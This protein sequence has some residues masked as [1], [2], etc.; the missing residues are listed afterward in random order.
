MRILILI[1]LPVAALGGTSH[2]TSDTEFSKDV[3][4]GDSS[5]D[6][7]I[8]NATTV[9]AA[10]VTFNGDVTFNEDVE[11][12]VAAD[13]KTTFTL[14]YFTQ[15]R[16]GTGGTPGIALGPD[17]VYV[18]GT[19]EVDGELQADGIFDA[20]STSDFADT[21]T[22]SKGS[23]DAVDISAGGSL[24]TDGPIDANSTS[25][26]A[27]TATFSKGS[28]D[29]ID[30]ASGGA[31]NIDGTVDCNG[32]AAFAEDVTIE[33]GAEV[34]FGT[35]GTHYEMTTGENPLEMHVNNSTNTGNWDEAANIFIYGDGGD[36]TGA[37]RALNARGYARS[38]S[39]YSEI[40]GADL[41]AIQLDGAYAARPLNL[42][43][44][45]FVDVEETEAADCPAEMVTPVFGIVANTGGATYAVNQAKAGI[46]GCVWDN[47]GNDADG[48][49]SMMNGDTGAAP[50]N[51]DTAYYA[52][53]NRRST[54][55]DVH[56]YGIDFYD[57]ATLVPAVRV[58]DIRL[59]NEEY[60]QNNVDGTLAMGVGGATVAY[61]DGTGCIADG[62]N[63]PIGTTTPAEGT[64][65]DV[66]G[67][68]DFSYGGDPGD[69]HLYTRRTQTIK[70]IDGFDM[71]VD[72][73]FA[74]IYDLTNVVG[75]GTNEVTSVDGWNTLTTA[76][77]GGPDSEETTFFGLNHYRVYEP[78]VETV[79]DFTATGGTFFAFG[80]YAA[81][82]E[83]CEI[84]YDTAV[85]AN[86]L[87][88]VDDTGGATT[89]DSGVAVTA[90]P[91]KLELW[92]DATGTPG[93][94]IDDVNIDPGA[95]DDMTASAH[96][97]R[98]N[99]TDIAGVVH[100]VSVDYIE[101]EQ[102]KMQ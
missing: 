29:A 45:M 100:T 88:V 23:G 64:F 57:A 83:L 74:L 99:I 92:V 90:D 13:D 20:N 37:I 54:S 93:W 28:G 52:I 33:D 25:D 9:Q 17:D 60:I 3:T 15:F 66:A 72:V 30:V 87:L 53:R 63:G 16:V 7:L 12:C 41:E 78:R 91:T 80:F 31:V 97:L 69:L 61:F 76:G 95:T 85:G 55:T 18:E 68:G 11:L 21:A 32:V 27:G 48:I 98:W 14:G 77:A 75:A 79:I 81:G 46:V 38:G 44:V 2:V 49:V 65:T 22:F 39:N 89:I 71:G 101:T 67:S 94:A 82:N 10:A 73:Q 4:I 19:E 86:W 43:N 58:A 26:F 84:Q 96:Y 6:T 56:A 51:P 34:S 40:Y 62:F 50:N 42:Y 47:A 5:A 24:N 102:L 1:L 36:G 70:F 8:I 35:P 59:Q